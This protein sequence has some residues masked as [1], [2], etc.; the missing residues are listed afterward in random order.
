M[1]S[2]LLLWSLAAPAPPV[3]PD[4]PLSALDVFPPAEYVT[5]S[6]EFNR[7]HQQWIVET[8]YLR[9]H[10]R[11]PLSLALQH[12]WE[13]EDLFWELHFAQEAGGSDGLWVG[14]LDRITG[15]GEMNIAFPPGAGRGNAKRVF[16]DSV[17]L[18][19]A[20][21]RRAL[22]RLRKSL[23]DDDF[24]HGRMPPPVPLW[25]CSERN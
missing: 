14:R 1:S 6:I 21:A 11:K 4:P 19:E 12:C 8:M 25:S 23:G 7:R 13:L 2:L 3:P 10:L 20:N 5:A 18:T 22:G 9:P 17:Q 15:A 24:A 16:F